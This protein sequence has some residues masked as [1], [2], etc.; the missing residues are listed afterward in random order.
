MQHTT[1]SAYYTKN[2]TYYTITVHTT[3]LQ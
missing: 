1:Y 2:N 3:L